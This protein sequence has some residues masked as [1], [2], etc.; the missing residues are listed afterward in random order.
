M[1][2]LTLACV[3][4]S[5][6]DYATRVD[7]DADGSA[8]PQDCDNRDATVF[9]G[10]TEVCDG[11]DQDCD[12]EVDEGAG[13]IWYEDDDQDGLGAEDEVTRAC[14]QP[15]GYVA[16]ATDCDDGDPQTGGP[17]EW[18]ADS[19]GD[20]AGN[21][22]DSV[23][24]CSP[25]DGYVGLG[26]DCDDQD[27]QL[28]PGTTWYEDGDGDGWGGEATTVA[29]DPGTGWALQ[30]GDCDDD[31]PQ[32]NPGE[33]ELAND[34][35]DND[36]DG[37]WARLSGSFSGFQAR[38][39]GAEGSEL[40]DSL[41]GLPDLDGDGNAEFLVGAYGDSAM[42][43]G[44]GAAFLF[45]GPFTGTLNAR[46]DADWTLRGYTD[47]GVGAAVSGGTD[48]TGG[49]QLDVVVSSVFAE[50]IQGQVW[51]FEGA[52]SGVDTTS[53][54]TWTLT[55]TQ[56]GD[57]FGN[58]LAPMDFNG[59]GQPDLAVA[60]NGALLSRGG[61][62]VYFGPLTG[63]ADAGD[64]DFVAI[65]PTINSIFAEALD[66]VGDVNGDGRD[67]MVVGA[68]H[69]DGNHD[70]QGAAYLFL[71]GQ[72]GNLAAGNADRRYVEEAADAY[73]GWDITPMGDVNDDGHADFALS[74]PGVSTNQGAVYVI[75][76]HGGTGISYLEDAAVILEGE[77][78]GHFFGSGIAGQDLDG[79]G[80]MDMVVGAPAAQ[81]TR[82]RVYVFYG[83]LSGVLGAEE[84][85]AAQSGNT[86]SEPIGTH[87]TPVGQLS[88][89]GRVGFAAAQP[90]SDD[91]A[92]AVLV[93]L[94]DGL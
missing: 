63:Q 84:A 59:D 50:D 15:D 37:G 80:V 78:N 88:G 91:N 61:A 52:P 55:G 17:S 46:Q 86:I 62:F 94:A 21:E 72:T 2:L 35:Y 43:S 87:L 74:A 40:G 53:S 1:L 42:Y 4:L 67:D 81:T 9:P 16:N 68:P 83:P 32:A 69:V 48:L 66:N 26:G 54:A 70:D 39:E 57:G 92:G 76:D 30:T 75:S 27:D 34:G 45:Y 90:L 77:A 25:P 23:H 65:G 13:E 14:E 28:H 11:V 41:V 20:Q 60:A 85:E 44:G 47:E 82:G 58:A 89:D 56:F 51:V 31:N 33:T 79:D 73:A 64:A 10:A 24:A 19:D 18:F 7:A 93:L 12:G 49:G 29:C 5:D 22:E 36:C 38:I 6:E 8:W 71:G 3:T